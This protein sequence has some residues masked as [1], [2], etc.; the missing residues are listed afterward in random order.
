MDRI[1]IARSMHIMQYI[2]HS[3]A[4]TQLGL[5]TDE[6]RM[7]VVGRICFGLWAKW[8]NF[9]NSFVFFRSLHLFF[10]FHIFSMKKNK[11]CLAV[12]GTVA[13]VI[14]STLCHRSVE[15]VEQKW[16]QYRNVY[17]IQRKRGRGR[18]STVFSQFHLPFIAL[19]AEQ[20][21]HT[22]LFLINKI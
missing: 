6:W 18:G 1:A 2:F 3:D 9:I 21:A 14:V 16:L 4:Q 17:R 11:I 13:V 10:F 12:V 20:R 15:N 22:W 7:A 19:H 5:R 8:V